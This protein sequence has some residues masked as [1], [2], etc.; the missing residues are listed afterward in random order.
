MIF[1]AS[2]QVRFPKKN[3]KRRNCFAMG[4]MCEQ[5]H[6]VNGSGH[7]SAMN[8]QG[9]SIGSGFIVSGEESALNERTTDPETVCS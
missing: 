2:G 9:A 4:I 1:S 6:V 5:V 7:L 3:A 8:E